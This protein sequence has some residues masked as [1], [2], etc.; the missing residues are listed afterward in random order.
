MKT[1]TDPDSTWQGNVRAANEA[2]STL[3]AS[4]AELTKYRDNA[5]AEISKYLRVDSLKGIELDPDAIR[6]TLTRPYT[7]FPINENE[8]W[9]I[10][11]R[12]V[13]ITRLRALSGLRR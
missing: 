7:L 8:A 6:A 3:E 13:K 12:G 2:L 5:T 1:K 10:H 4:I 11:W 9:L